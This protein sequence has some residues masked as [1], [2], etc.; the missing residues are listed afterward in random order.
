MFPFGLKGAAA[1]AISAAPTCWVAVFDFIT[2]Y[3][4]PADLDVDYLNGWLIGLGDGGF[5]IH[6]VHSA[7]RT[8]HCLASAT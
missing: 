2:V 3:R 8:E 6:S 5:P 1:L 4:R 7:I